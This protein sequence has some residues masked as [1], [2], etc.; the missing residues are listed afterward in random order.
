[1]KQFFYGS[2]YLLIVFVIAGCDLVTNNTP[3]A[4]T[5]LGK[6]LI[7]TEVFTISPDRYY[8]YSWIEIYNPTNRSISWADVSQPARGIIVGD[9]GVILETPE[10]GRVWNVLPSNT[11]AGIR[12]LGFEYPDS[13]LAVGER[14]TVLKSTDA[15]ATW[16]KWPIVFADSS[17]PA[18]TA[19]LNGISYPSVS[20][21]PGSRQGWLVGDGGV[22]VHTS[23]KGWTWD[24]QNST[25]TANI[26]SIFSKVSAT[27]LYATADNG[28]VLMTKNS[29]VKWTQYPVSRSVGLY[30]L[31]LL[32]GIGAT[33]DSIWVC[34]EQGLIFH[35]FQVSKEAPYWILEN[36]GVTA[37]LRAIHFPSIPGISNPFAGSGNGWAVGDNGTIIHTSNYGETWRTQISGTGVQLNAVRFVD[38]LHGFV[39]GNAGTV[40]YTSNGGSTWLHQTSGTSSNLY[41]AFFFSLSREVKNYYMLRMRAQRKFYYQ[42]LNTGRINDNYYTMID[43]GFA[44]YAPYNLSTA[45][46]IADQPVTAGS[47]VV[48]ASDSGAFIDHQKTGPASTQVHYAN[49]IQSIPVPPGVYNVNGQTGVYFYKDIKWNLLSSGEV[50]LVNYHAEERETTITVQGVTV[51][52]KYVASLDSTILDVVRY[53]DYVPPDG[54]YPGNKSGPFAPLN[55]SNIPEWSSLARYQNDYGFEDPTQM[56]SAYSFYLTTDPIPGWNSQIKRNK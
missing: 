31:S 49:H 15:G 12:G 36:T 22:I 32:S 51:T 20:D 23:N 35:S 38:S 34:G 13:A 43:T 25:T 52:Y 18:L 54:R 42:E 26:H 21:V 45:E 7:V 27:Y 33:N 4:Q 5:Q 14:G 37:T 9:N 2:L 17:A 3:P 56:N 11:D 40:L 53:G 55:I 50:Y 10:D 41:G 16:A 29:G 6:D 39:L 8:A 48:I 47:F 24:Y 46:A 1:M 19:N 30:G 44:Y 28:I